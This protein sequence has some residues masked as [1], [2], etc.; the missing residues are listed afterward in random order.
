MGIPI[1]RGRDVRAPRKP[2]SDASDASST[3]PEASSRFC[4]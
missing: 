1:K 3:E 2:A 4:S